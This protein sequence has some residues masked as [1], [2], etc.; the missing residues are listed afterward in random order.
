M[1]NQGD[2]YIAYRKQE[3]EQKIAETEKTISALQSCVND[4]ES[5]RKEIRNI[6]E[7]EDVYRQESLLKTDIE[8]CNRAIEN[9]QIMLR[10][11][12]EIVSKLDD[13]ARD[14]NSM[15][16]DAESIV[17]GLLYDATGGGGHMF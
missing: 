4:L 6:W 10:G 17:N 12:K 5:K 8:G 7:D 3:Y 15:F 9:A 2:Q 11:L 16:D 13:A 1:A 14:V